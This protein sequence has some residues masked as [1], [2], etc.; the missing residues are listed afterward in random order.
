MRSKVGLAEAVRK[1]ARSRRSVDRGGRGGGL[2]ALGAMDERQPLNAAPEA[3]ERDLR[4]A[5]EV[6]SLACEITA[7]AG[8]DG[9]RPLF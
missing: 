2:L 4:P 6:I 5:F 3:S 9:E 8:D 7:Y 1:S